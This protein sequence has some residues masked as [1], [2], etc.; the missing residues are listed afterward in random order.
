MVGRNSSGWF[1]TFSPIQLS[2]PHH[3]SC[4]GRAHAIY[5]GERAVG[6]VFSGKKR[7]CSLTLGKATIARDSLIYA[8]FLASINPRSE[9][10]RELVSDRILVQVNAANTALSV[11]VLFPAQG[12]PRSF[13]PHS[14]LSP[15]HHCVYRRTSNR[16]HSL[17]QFGWHCPTMSLPCQLC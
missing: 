5:V 14:V 16:F 12:H 3:C 17:K 6:K 8:W 13:P 7:F 1:E 11:Q 9:A 10:V 4:A 15:P 2:L